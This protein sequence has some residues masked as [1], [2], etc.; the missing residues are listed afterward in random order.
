MQVT[1]VGVYVYS[2]FTDEERVVVIINNGDDQ[3]IDLTD[4]YAELLGEY[5][6]AKD[7]VSGVEYGDLS[8]ISIKEK[9]ALVLEL[10]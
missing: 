6:K 8:S 4:R 3:I 7:A 2:R 1:L 9:S 5:T 10:K